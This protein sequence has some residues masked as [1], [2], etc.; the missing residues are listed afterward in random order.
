M[1]QVSWTCAFGVVVALTGCG[2]GGGGGHGGGSASLGISQPG[3]GS[4]GSAP[5]TTT[6]VPFDAGVLGTSSNPIDQAALIALK[7]ASVSPVALSGDAEFIRRVTADTLGR[8]PTATEVST[9]VADATPTKR[10][11]AVDALLASPEFATHWANDVL[12]SWACVS[13]GTV[14]FQAALQADLT[15]NMTLGAIVHNF[16]TGTGPEGSIFVTNFTDPTTEIDQL[17]Q[18]FTGLTSECARCHDHK[19]TTSAD[20]PMWVQDDN[21]SLYA[22]LGTPSQATKVN[23]SGKKFGTPLQPGWVVDGYNNAVTTGLPALTDPLPTRA[24]KFADLFT[25]SNA[26]ARGTAHRIFAE[27][28][29]P[30]LDPNQFLASNLANVQQPAVLDELATVFKQQN[31]SLQGFLS[32]VLKSKL[33][34]LTTAGTTTANDQLLARRTVRRHHS[35]VIEAGVSMVAGVPF[36]T[37]KF[38]QQNFGYPIP[39]KMM[40][41]LER[42]D[43]VNL[44]Q[45]LTLMNSPV[46]ITGLEMASG[47]DIPT[48]ATQVTSGKMSRSDAITQIITTA[49]GRAPTATELAAVVSVCTG[50][51]SDLEALEDVAQAVCTTTEFV[52][53]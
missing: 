39:Q 27:V 25:A 45:T 47:S 5:V 37:Q 40:T 18:S 46:S 13:S 52:A 15:A 2:S 16:C 1:R 23:T 14:A 28:M 24:A 12:T 31:L 11:T 48:L 50:A 53:R 42:T 41:L 30:L 32:V 17:M 20:N 8:L 19:L 34:Q 35:E 29:D 4:T 33:Y 43:G 7:A 21:Y 22:F 38:F 44:S 51:A 3:S 36:K 26:F 6:T 10:D 49:L 9:F